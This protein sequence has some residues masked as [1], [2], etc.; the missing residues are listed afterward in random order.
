MRQCIVNVLRGKSHFFLFFLIILFLKNI[1]Q[2]VASPTSLLFILFFSLIFVSPFYLI[3][4]W[5][6]QLLMYTGLYKRFYTLKVN[7]TFK[8]L[9]T[10]KKKFYIQEL[11]WLSLNSCTFSFTVLCD[12]LTLVF[13][14]FIKRS[15]ELS[16]CLF[17]FFFWFYAS[18]NETKLD[19][20]KRT[21]KS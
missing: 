15:F 3:G 6:I 21:L 11:G 10:L 9:V 18:I 1:I 8:T 12:A 5:Y 4:F 19:I 17:F 2:T 16:L 14:Q 13:L 20:Y 7:L